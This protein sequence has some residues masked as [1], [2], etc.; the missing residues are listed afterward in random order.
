MPKKVSEFE[1]KK[2][3]DSFLNGIT[4]DQLSKKYNFSKITISR[5]L[6]N[7]LNIKVFQEIVKKNNTKNSKELN[8]IDDTSI[9]DS[10]KKISQEKMDCESPFYEIPPLNYEIDNEPQKDLA[11]VSILNIE[12]PKIVYMIVDS[13]IELEIKPLRDYPEW[14]FLSSNELNKNTIEIYFDL[15]VAKRFCGK[16]QKV[17]KVPNSNIFSLVAPLLVSRGISRIV[18]PDKLIAL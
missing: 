9:N 7:A 15:K 10:N 5:H 12:L 18:C 6:K 8:N 2:I 16:Q 3:I 13:K 1:K 4:I 17:I 11:S 14:Q